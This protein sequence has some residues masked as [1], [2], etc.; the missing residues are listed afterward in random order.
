MAFQSK[1]LILILLAFFMFYWACSF[2]YEANTW[3]TDFCY[4]FSCTQKAKSLT[5]S[6][7][8]AWSFSVY[9]WNRSAE[10]IA[11]DFSFVDAEEI[12]PSV[13]ACKSE[14]QTSEVWQ[15][16][17]AD[18]LS[19]SIQPGTWLEKQIYYEF[20]PSYSWT[21]YGCVTYRPDWVYTDSSA[22]TIPRKALPFS[23]IANPQDIT[24]E[25]VANLGSRWKNSLNERWFQSDWLL[26][27][28][29]L[30]DSTIPVYTWYVHLNEYWTW[31]FDTDVTAGYYNIVYKWFHHLSSYLTNVY[32]DGSVISFTSWN[33]LFWVWI[34][35]IWE[36]NWWL[37][38]Q[39]AWDLPSSDNGRYDYLVNTADLSQILWSCW[40]WLSVPKWHVCDLNNDTMID[41]NDM[42]VVL[43][44]LYQKDP[45]FHTDNKLYWGLDF[46]VNY[47]E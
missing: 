18:S 8:D 21:Y 25:I 35:E 30:D 12:L 28:Y 38:Y 39:I 36:Y 47:Y 10:T 20:P 2:W 11:W 5:V 27:F 26:L 40:Y 13:I 19:F 14:N 15:Y 6:W 43:N 24:V 41:S 23:I 17:S 45:V 16:L 7:S 22:N 46:G 37:G 42:T 3:Y 4:D 34:S 32:V 31:T 33:N 1:N 44:N 9:L 29:N